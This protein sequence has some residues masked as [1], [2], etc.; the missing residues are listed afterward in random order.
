MSTAVYIETYGCQM[1]VADSELMAGVLAGEG[2]VLVER[3]EQADVVLL[4]TCAVRERAEERIIGRLGWLKSAKA[5]RPELVLGVVGCMAERTKES[6]LAR[7]P[8]VD[9]V[10]G[11]DA[12]RRL[13][14][15][16]R[17]ARAEAQDPLV[18]VR[19]DRRELYTGIDP[20]RADGVSGFITIMRGCDR[21]CS[22][23]IVPFVRGRERSVPPDEVLRQAEAMEQQGFRELTLLGQTVSGYRVGE[24]GFAELLRALHARTTMRLRFTSPYPTDFADPRLLDTLAELPRVG[25]HLHLPLQS[26]S[27]AVLEDMGRGYSAA[28]YRTLIAAVRARLPDFALSTDVIVGYPGETEADFAATLAL[29]EEVGFDSAFMFKYSERAGTRASRAR[30]DDLPDAVKV[31]RLARLLALQERSSRARHAA[32]I[33]RTVEVLVTGTNPRDAQTMLGRT[34]CFRTTVVA[35]PPCA[36]GTLLP[37]L[38][39]RASAHTLFAGAA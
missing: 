20:Q 8:Y 33:G 14:Q 32:L 13:P 2:F 35:G 7:A 12:Y 30:P 31:E 22:F 23:C 1:N 3:E 5:A 27:T 16:L 25:R 11:P 29:V 28:Q 18:D 21:F 38:V 10:I 6:L 34:S 26:G 24:V 4:N 9:L 19:L 36:P 39:H 17:E 37:A 15:L